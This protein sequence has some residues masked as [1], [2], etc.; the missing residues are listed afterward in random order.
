VE[1]DRTSIHAVLIHIL[2][3]RGVAVAEALAGTYPV[4]GIF[5]I[6]ISASL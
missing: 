5:P 1:L 4:F 6:G 3:E 2:R